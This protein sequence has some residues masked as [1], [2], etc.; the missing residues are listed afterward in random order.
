MASPQSIV[1]ANT[2]VRIQQVQQLLE[3]YGDSRKGDPALITYRKEIA[4]LPG[5][6]GPPAGILL[7]ALWEHL[8][9]GC[10]ALR[11]LEEH[12]GEVKRLYVHP[13]FRRKGIAQQLM[14]RLLVEAEARGYLK[15]RLDSIP[16]MQAA[17]SLY[18]QMGFHEIPP[19]WQNPNAGTRY[20]E[21]K[22]K[23]S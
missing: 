23:Q 1:L 6:Y 5:K 18:E 7:L 8:P 15:V 22:F 9:A 3:A 2:E 13:D 10:V 4:D 21:W 12:I 11:P 17:Q 19:Y 16:T 14:E 20:F